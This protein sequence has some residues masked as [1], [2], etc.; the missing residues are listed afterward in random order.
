M[1]FKRCHVT[2]PIVTQKYQDEPWGSFL[3]SP[4][5]Q[6]ARKA[7]M[8]YMQDRGFNS[9]ASYMI[10][11]SV[12]ETKWSSLLARSLALIFYISIWIFNFGP[13]ELPGLSRNG[14]L[15][16]VK[17]TR[18][19]LRGA[20][21]I[22]SIPWMLYKGKSLSL[23]TSNTCPLTFKCTVTHLI[24]LLFSH[25]SKRKINDFLTVLEGFNKA[26]E[27]VTLFKDHV[28]NFRYVYRRA[29]IR[30][31]GIFFRQDFL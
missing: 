1:R 9:F 8:V 19:P 18:S 25:C 7:V 5:N 14:S 11:L 23:K 31:L 21:K 26:T 29:S 16:T 4:D 12:N 20:H 10:K 22:H 6:R 28:S 3:E 15:V 17:Y 2:T 30:C 13:E 27:I 24:T